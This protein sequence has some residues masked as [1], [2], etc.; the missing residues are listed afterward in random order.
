[1]NIELKKKI[2]RII[3]K[4]IKNYYG[5]SELYEPCYDIDLLAD[6]LALKLN[7]R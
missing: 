4:Y 2:K 7:K 3:R 5:E 1:M 6:V